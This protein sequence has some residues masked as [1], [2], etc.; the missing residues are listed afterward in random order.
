MQIQLKKSNLKKRNQIMISFLFLF[1]ILFSLCLI[2]P[3]S[4][5]VEFMQERYFR[6][7]NT[8]NSMQDHI[9]FF[10]LSKE[11]RDYVADDKPIEAYITYSIYPKTWN[12]DN[13]DYAVQY[14]N[15]SVL[16]SGALT[17]SSYISFN[18]TIYPTQDIFSK[19]YYKRINE[20]DGI[21]VDA[22]CVFEDEMPDTLDMP[23]TIR[24]STPTW[25]CKACQFYEWSKSQRDVDKAVI[26]GDYTTEIIEY[27]KDLIQLNYEILL[28]LFWFAMIMILF[29]AIFLIFIG[30]FWLYLYL[31]KLAK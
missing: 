25:N 6:V 24:L 29:S 14:C 10:Y 8:T 2:N 11:T 20:N 21:I 27:I 16:Y 3:V 5:N 19:K 4:A 31:N 13:P 28:A 9:I 26:L 30:I 1:L 18:E 12:T 15:I 17:N 7:T 23:I 22:F